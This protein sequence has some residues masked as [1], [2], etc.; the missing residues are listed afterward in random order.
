MFIQ[1]SLSGSRIILRPFSF[2]KH[3]WGIWMQMGVIG[4]IC[5]RLL[6]LFLSLNG[7]K[8]WVGNLMDQQK[9]LFGYVGTRMIWQCG[10]TAAH[11]SSAARRAEPVALRHL[12]QWRDQALKVVLRPQ[13]AAQMVTHMVKHHTTSTNASEL[14]MEDQTPY[15]NVTCMKNTICIIYYIYL[16]ICI[17]IICSILL[18]Y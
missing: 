10:C 18:Y 8:I 6:F 14:K 3:P 9:G 5:D 1:T 4:E 15:H 2:Q 13:R 17:H 7:E 16:Y 11:H 12:C